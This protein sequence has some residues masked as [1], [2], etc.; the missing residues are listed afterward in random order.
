MRQTYSLTAQTLKVLTDRVT[1]IATEM[2]VDPAYLHQILNSTESDS[3]GKFKRLYAAAVRADAPVC[4]WDNELA[5]IRARYEKLL[6]DLSIV[7]CFT[8]KIN[9]NAR[10]CEQ[11]VHALQDGQI[12]DIES[13]RILLAID[14]ERK[15][16]N[17]IEDLLHARTILPPDVRAAAVERNGRAK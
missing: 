16:F 9:A 15:I 2:D 7:E 1:A 11:L 14:Q 12:D 13:D 5:A 3:F 6:P 8:G 4:H 17:Q 10:T